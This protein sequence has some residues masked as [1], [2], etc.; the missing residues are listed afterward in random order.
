MEKILTAAKV[1]EAVLKKT[2]RCEKCFDNGLIDGKICECAME[3]AEAIK[4][5]NAFLRLRK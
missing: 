1:D 3:R 2:Y 4:R 5:Y